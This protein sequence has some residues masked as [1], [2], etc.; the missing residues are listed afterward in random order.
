MQFN[1]FWSHETQITTAAVI[2]QNVFSPT[3]TSMPF[4]V[5][6]I[7]TPATFPVSA[8]CPYSF[9][10]L[11]I[12][13]KWNHAWSGLCVWLVRI[14]LLR[15]FST[16]LIR[17]FVFFAEY[18]LLWTHDIVYPLTSWWTFGFF[19]RFGLFWVKLLWTFEY[20]SLGRHVFSFFLSNF[21]ELGLLV[22][23][24]GVCLTL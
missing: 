17:W 7:S 24:V 5:C 13:R 22:H 15:F 19:S 21:L 23:I 11:R 8:F 9:D 14:M 4:A 2:I 18:S 16:L 3:K 20:K 6:S 10:T 12:L 1:E